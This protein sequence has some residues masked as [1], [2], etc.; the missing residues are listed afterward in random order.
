MTKIEAK[1]GSKIR[2]G[3]AGTIEVTVPE[4][5]SLKELTLVLPKGVSSP[6]GDK[7]KLAPKMTH[8]DIPILVGKEAPEHFT[9]TFR[10]REK[11][12]GKSKQVDLTA[13]YEMDIER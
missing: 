1:K 5:K 13:D 10:L 7:L 12:L 8:V 9:I 2:K 4:T 3:E 6:E 11:P